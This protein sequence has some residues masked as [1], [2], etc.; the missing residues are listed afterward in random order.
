MN[1]EG[2]PETQL[3][4]LKKKCLH[5]LTNIF[6]GKMR[7]ISLVMIMTGCIH[8]HS[9]H[10]QD[11]TPSAKQFSVID[12][13]LTAQ[14]RHEWWHFPVEA[15]FSHLESNTKITI[16]GFWNGDNNYVLRFSPTLAGA[17]SYTTSST[18]PGL[19]NV[20]GRVV[21]TAPTESEV[22]D[23]PNYHGHLT[24][25]R[26]GRY[27]EYADGTP[28]FLL[29]D[30][31]W[32]LNTS[33]CGLGNNKDGP[34]YQYL[35]D[36]K[37]KKY[38]TILMSF[39]RG[40]GDT[41]EPAGQRNEGGYPFIN[42]K[43][44]QLNPSYFN[45]LD[46]RLDAIWGHGLLAAAN[47]TWF[48]K[49]NCFFDLTW[50]KRISA[51]LMNR[52]SAFNGIFSVSGEYQYAMEDCRWV[53]ESFE[54]IGNLIRAY[55][56]YHKPVSI[57]PSGRTN[58]P[59]PHGVQSSREFH[60][61]SWLDHNWLQTGQSA[62]L[63]FNIA[64]RALENYALSPVKPVFLSE[65]YYESALDPDHTY[66]SRWQPW[67][68]FLNGA[69]GFGYGAD[70]MWQ[71]FNPGDPKGETGKNVKSPLP[72]W[73]AINFAGANQMQYARQLLDKYAWWKLTPHREWLTINGQKNKLPTASDIT[74]PHCAAIPGEL[75]I[76][77]LPRSN[78]DKSIEITNLGKKNYKAIWFNPRSGSEM[79]IQD[80]P[81]KVS[82]WEIPARPIPSQEDWVLV[83]VKV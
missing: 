17:W 42:G 26:N 40:F 16:H 13:S 64:G 78:S 63:I 73:E 19:N 25:S 28:F 70:G 65:A 48:G 43:S 83:L 59:A 14:D 23:N 58:W 29:A 71:F 75:L 1:K 56:P 22:A 36:R 76:V 27:F 69:A 47:V 12:F 62:A 24:I 30:T 2:N 39:M 8:I 5:D 33:R 82:Q 53:R 3:K 41:E 37:S 54:E 57:H 52:Y 7:M 18:D 50:A 46:E 32:A 44:L 80:P 79:I 74:P 35:A 9:S 4:H 38:S 77:Y 6:C 21:A 60:R 11:A 15:I 31:N 49:L 10:A 66:H 51:Y 45:Y 61:S 68:A 55:N 81:D 34:F 67:A 20:R 72:W